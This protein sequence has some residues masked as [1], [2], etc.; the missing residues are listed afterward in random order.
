MDS[1]IR[2]GRDARRRLA[3]LDTRGG[4]ARISSSLP[5]RRRVAAHAKAAVRRRKFLQV[6]VFGPIE[7]VY[8]A[9]LYARGI[10]RVL[11]AAMVAGRDKK[12]KFVNLWSKLNLK[13]GRI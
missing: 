13:C 6:E 5:A 2:S 10:G 11:V 7:D 3:Q 1:I 8:P 4:A 9:V 12:I